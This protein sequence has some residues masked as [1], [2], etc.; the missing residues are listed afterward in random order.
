MPYVITA[1]IV[2]RAAESAR[3]A[4]G[5]IAS[6]PSADQVRAFFGKK[7]TLV[8]NNFVL[9]ADFVTLRGGTKFRVLHG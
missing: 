3:D 5:M 6:I 9:A 2:M 8:E 7:M 1:P 4:R